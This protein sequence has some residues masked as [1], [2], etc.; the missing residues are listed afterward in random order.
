ML[1]NTHISIQKYKHTPTHYSRPTRT[2]NHLKRR[3]YKQTGIHFVSIHS[4]IS[5]EHH[6]QTATFNCSDP[7]LRYDHCLSYIYIYIYKCMHM[8]CVCVWVFIYYLV[9]SCQSLR[10]RMKQ[11][12]IKSQPVSSCSRF[13]PSLTHKGSSTLIQHSEPYAEVAGAQHLGVLRA[14]LCGRRCKLLMRF[15]SLFPSISLSFAFS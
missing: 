7:K 9:N 3:F 10:H 12:D 11:V 8:L 4:A 5:T 1:L 15:L 14:L 6:P 13:L 2:Q